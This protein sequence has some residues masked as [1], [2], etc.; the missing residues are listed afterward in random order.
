MRRGAVN[1][2]NAKENCKAVPAVTPNKAICPL[3]RP[4]TLHAW[5]GAGWRAAESGV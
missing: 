3:L 2:E 1:R 5:E 4:P